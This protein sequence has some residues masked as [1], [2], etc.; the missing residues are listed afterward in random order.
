MVNLFTSLRSE[1]LPWGNCAL[2]GVRR[3]NKM[4]SRCGCL[5]PTSFLL[6]RVYTPKAR[7]ISSRACHRSAPALAVACQAGS[8]DA[9]YVRPP[10][11]MDIGESRELVH[12]PAPKTSL[13]DPIFERSRFASTLATVSL[14]FH[15]VGKTQK[16]LSHGACLIYTES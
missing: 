14:F 7:K 4:I 16:D 8:H 13:D 15:N 2:V 10:I 12:P 11:L 5:R 1:L 3:A 6:P 9:S